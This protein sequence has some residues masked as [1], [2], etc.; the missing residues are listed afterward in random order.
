[1]ATGVDEDDARYSELQYVTPQQSRQAQPQQHLASHHRSHQQ[2]LQQPQAQNM[3]QEAASGEW[4]N[5]FLQEEGYEVTIEYPAKT[6]EAAT[7]SASGS[8]DPNPA[9]AS[10]KKQSI[11]R[12][13][14]DDDDDDDDDYEEREN[15]RRDGEFPIY[16]FAEVDRSGWPRAVR[17][18]TINNHT[19][20]KVEIFQSG[21]HI[22]YQ[23]VADGMVNASQMLGCLNITQ[24]HANRILAVL[25]KN[26]G[27]NSMDL[28]DKK[29]N[30]ANGLWLVSRISPPPPPTFILII[31]PIFLGHV[32]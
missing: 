18:K 30:V 32:F 9:P 2:Q 27:S 31:I 7:E 22:V 29:D 3:F 10:K 24:Y 19:M 4:E 1:M 11:S 25:L 20:G 6:I 5:N 8:S 28:R 15:R 14:G 26:G 23:R 16:T 13:R 17:G 21:A 12:S